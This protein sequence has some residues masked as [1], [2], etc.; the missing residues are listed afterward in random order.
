MVFS[1]TGRSKRRKKIDKREYGPFDN[2]QDCKNW[3]DLKGVN[4]IGD[5]KIIA[6]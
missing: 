1:I 4:S 6:R 3:I 5:V 2:E